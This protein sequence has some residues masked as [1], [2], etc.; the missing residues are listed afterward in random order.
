MI[1]NAFSQMIVSPWRCMVQKWIRSSLLNWVSC[2]M[3]TMPAVNNWHQKECANKKS[4]K[5]YNSRWWVSNRHVNKAF[6]LHTWSLGISVLPQLLI[7]LMGTR[8][9][10]SRW[11]W[12]KNIIL[13]ILTKQYEILC[14]NNKKEMQK[15]NNNDDDKK[16]K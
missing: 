5:R 12:K 16:I 3:A 9:Q 14:S 1:T 2:E 10:F 11:F 8:L 15:N 13:C 6:R 4:F 7:H